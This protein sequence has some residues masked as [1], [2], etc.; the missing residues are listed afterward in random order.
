MAQP[1]KI[2]SGKQLVLTAGDLDKAIIGLLTNGIAAS[3]VNGANMPAGFTR[4]LA[5]RGG[6]LN[7][8]DECFDRI[9]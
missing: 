9:A 7:N 6:V 4:V 1:V 5:F 2:P 3:D 8:M